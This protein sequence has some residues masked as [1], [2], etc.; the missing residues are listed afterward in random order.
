M[1]KW[2]DLLITLTALSTLA[3]FL[4][5]TIR[6][7]ITIVRYTFYSRKKMN[8]INTENTEVNIFANR[9]YRK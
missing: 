2:L 4:A 9:V 5:F 6:I 8:D 1:D 3:C 7:A